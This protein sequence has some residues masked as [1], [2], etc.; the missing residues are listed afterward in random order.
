MGPHG[1]AGGGQGVVQHPVPVR[2]VRDA[3]ALE[4]QA[5]RSTA[6]LGLLPVELLWKK[7]SVV[8]VIVLNQVASPGLV[9]ISASNKLDDGKTGDVV[10]VFKDYDEANLCR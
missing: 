1:A 3:A 8:F 2:L 6:P 9:R 5:E 7:N 10:L 4:L